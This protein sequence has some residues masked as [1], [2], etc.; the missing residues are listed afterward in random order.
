[1]L[2]EDRTQWKKDLSAPA[3]YCRLRHCGS[4]RRFVI[5]AASLSR[6]ITEIGLL[7]GLVGSLIVGW[8]AY[9]VIRGSFER[10]RERMAT[11]F[12]VA[13]ISLAFILQLLG[14]LTVS[15][16]KPSPSPS[17]S[18]SGVAGSPATKAP[19]SPSPSK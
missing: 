7:L 19:G 16:T 4:A 10:E 1:M 3:H 6:R 2:A 9:G 13:L 5:A 15:K 8:G 11:L 18:P 17:L 12:G 14:V